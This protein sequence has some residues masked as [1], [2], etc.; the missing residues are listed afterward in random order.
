[1]KFYTILILCF[2]SC[3]STNTEST[4]TEKIR[5]YENDDFSLQYPKE[6]HNHDN[7]GYPSFSP[8]L[9]LKRD[10]NFF[11]NVLT[12]YKLDHERDK[13]KTIDDFIKD[14]KE[15]A[16]TSTNETRFQ[17]KSLNTKNGTAIIVE[18]DERR[19]YRPMREITFF[20]TN[21]EI[22]YEL[23][24]RVRSNIYDEYIN[25]ALAIIDSFEFKN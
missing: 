22:I 6:W 25:E 1:M 17:Q 20:L 9:Y 24:Y 11:D 4:Q 23:K 7:H 13:S 16:T 3:G 10:R 2:F 18:L 14:K 12:I 19:D 5:V 21:N 8:K 15:R